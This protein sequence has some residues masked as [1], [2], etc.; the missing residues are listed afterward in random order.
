VGQ[1]QPIGRGLRQLRQPDADGARLG[2][3]WTY[4]WI[5]V[6]TFDKWL[7]ANQDRLGITKLGI[8]QREKVKPGDIVIFDWNLNMDGDHTQIVSAVEI[9]DGVTKIKMVGH[10]KDTDWRDFDETI[11]IDHPGA[12]AH[13]WSL[14]S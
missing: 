12:H 11:T 3:D 4:S 7:G 1:L 8:E 6:P 9:V 10:N 13:F 14:P 2:A 5:H